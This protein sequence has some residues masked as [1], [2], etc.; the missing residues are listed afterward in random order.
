L[1]RD[2]Q[3]TL[4]FFPLNDVTIKVSRRRTRRNEDIVDGTAAKFLGLSKAHGIFL[5][6]GKEVREM[7]LDDVFNCQVPNQAPSP[8]EKAERCA[9]LESFIPSKAVSTVPM[10]TDQSYSERSK[11]RRV[12]VEGKKKKK[13]NESPVPP[14]NPKKRKK[15]DSDGDS[16]E[17]DDGE[18]SKPKPKKSRRN[19]G[20]GTGRHGSP[21]KV[22]K[23]KDKIDFHGT[24]MSGIVFLTTPDFAAK[25]YTVTIQ[26]PSKQ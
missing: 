18:G 17:E 16:S 21:P 15:E 1:E 19:S 25:G 12:T 2:G 6:I 8:E 7:R 20:R 26:P 24:E 23:S 13:E 11:S 14:K 3:K 9:Y 4:Y 10:F 5:L 22:V